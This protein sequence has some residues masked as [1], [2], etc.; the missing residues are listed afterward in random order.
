[1]QNMKN[2]IYENQTG[3]GTNEVLTAAEN[4]KGFILHS[5]GVLNRNDG[6]NS[7]ILVDGNIV[8]I[9][10]VADGDASLSSILPES[11]I[12]PKDVSLALET[13]FNSDTAWCW[14]EVIT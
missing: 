12:F 2:A 5:A 10:G 14:Y 4:T 7:K 3:S 6:S 13:S 11:M 9:A 8:I 1:M